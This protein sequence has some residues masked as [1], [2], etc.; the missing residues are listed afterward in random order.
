MPPEQGGNGA[1]MLAALVGKSSASG[2]A[3]LAGSLIGAKNNSALFV[4]LLHSGTISGHLIDKFDLQRVYHKRYRDSTAKRLAHLTKITE[5][6]KN[7]V[8]TIVVT[9]EDRNRAKEL[10]QA[11][12]DE[13]NGLVARVNTSSAHREREFIEQRLSTVQA[14]L[15]RAQLEL[16][17]FSSKNTTIDLK[18]QT[19]AT[20]DAGAKLEGQ[21]IAG[22]SELSSLRQIY[23]DQ[24]VRVR[25][26]EAR[27]A[28]LR[29]EL[30]RANEQS[31]QGAEG[32]NL[33][34]A[35]PYPALRDL[36]RLGVH[37]ANLYRTVRIHE[38]VFD[39]LSEEYETARIDEAKSIPT[40]GIIDFPSL[41]E[42]KSGPHRLLIALTATVL[43]IILTAIYLLA[44]QF[45]EELD[46]FDPRRELVIH[47]K[48]TITSE[49][50][51]K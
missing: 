31:S 47:I 39:L 9:D 48:S 16:S 32:E 37:W 33:D 25:A 38:T 28:I 15:Q 11:Y 34:V 26:A 8:I 17:D 35:H 43:S 23:G 49:R 42:R 30:Q 29:R 14:E 51:R 5:D 45:W 3:G 4:A 19:K 24:N 2:L 21:L 13:L 10:A 36:P 22:E 7:G 41:P 6:P 40:V 20:V 27:D 44:K 50:V 18:E 46:A 12:L 1:A